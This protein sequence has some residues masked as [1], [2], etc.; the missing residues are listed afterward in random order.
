VSAGVAVA[1]GLCLAVILAVI[2]IAA[3][4][5]PEQ[6]SK[7]EQIRQEQLKAEGRI[8]A[9]TYAALHRLHEEARR[10]SS[11]WSRTP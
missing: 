5:L 8:T 4:V 10:G 6:R 3:F 11:P 2:F 7:Q 9:A 1:V